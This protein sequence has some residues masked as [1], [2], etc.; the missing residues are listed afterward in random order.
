MHDAALRIL[1]MSRVLVVDDNRDLA[2]NLV[3][4][5]D[6]EGHEARAAYDAQQAL[7]CAQGFEFD[8]AL[9]DIRM[10]DM[11]GVALVHRLMRDHPRSCYLFMTGY[12]SEPTLAEATAVS[13]RAVLGKPLDIPRLLRLV[14]AAGMA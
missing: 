5:L 4:V 13:Q 7:A 8:A 2:D 1:I 10:P 6:A 12:S 3:E 11:D 9:V 14:V